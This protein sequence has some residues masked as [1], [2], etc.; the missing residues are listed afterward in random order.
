MGFGVKSPG[1]VVLAWCAVYTL[2]APAADRERRREEIRSHVWETFDAWGAGW[3]TRLRLASACARGV[4]A[5]LAWCEEMRRASG[6]PP[7]V[8][9]VLV[10][11]AGA[12]AFAGFLIVGTYLAS[13]LEPHGMPN[14]VVEV[15]GALAAAFVLVSVTDRAL[16]RLTSRR[17]G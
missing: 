17:G 12:T 6:L 2:A 5:D 15:T 1:R 8:A 9:A 7:L 3:R 13:T 4:F 11:P 14:G 10:S 16:R